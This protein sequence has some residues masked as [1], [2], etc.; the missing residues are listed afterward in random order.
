MSLREDMSKFQMPIS[1]QNFENQFLQDDRKPKKSSRYTIISICTSD[2]NYIKFFYC[3]HF[4]GGV[5]VELVIYTCDFIVST[6]IFW[7]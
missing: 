1:S 4:C 3:I 2:C 5:I 6:T 7:K